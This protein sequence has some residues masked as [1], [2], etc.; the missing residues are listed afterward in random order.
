MT[1]IIGTK[2]KDYLVGDDNDDQIFGLDDDD[3][4]V[5]NG[6]ND[7]LN[8]GAGGDHMYGGDGNDSYFV[9][10]RDDLVVEMRG[11]GYDYVHAW[12]SYTLP[13]NVEGLMLDGP[14][15]INGIGNNIDNYMYG[16]ASSNVLWGLGGDDHI[17]GEGGADLMYGGLGDDTFYV[18][19]AYDTIFEYLDEGDDKVLA[20]VDYKLP[21]NVENLTL[22][23]KGTALNGTGNDLD[24]EIWGNIADNTLSGEDGGD[25]L[26][27]GIGAD[28][29]IGGDGDDTYYVDDVGDQV[30]ET[31]AK[32]GID[33]V[34]SSISYTL[35]A[36]EERLLL[37]DAGGAI[38]GIGNDLDNEIAGNGY[39]NVLTGGDGNDHFRLFNDP[40]ISEDDTITD[41]HAGDAYGDVIEMWGYN[42]AGGFAELLP[43][44][45]QV[46]NDVVGNFDSF[47]T[48]TLQ[49]VQ[50]SDLNANDFL[51][52]N[53]V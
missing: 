30:I 42:L 32:G 51:F 13:G 11:G 52:Y 49:N 25:V 26:I 36:F 21:D 1:M 46:G 38:D 40:S 3:V 23:D 31:S 47:N 37:S 7:W 39:S 24:N 22:L 29:M 33:Q 34:R 48:L 8:G 50:L 16:N 45:S 43:Y 10:S 35:G 53:P 18:D 6:G 17:D 4:L 2:G 41:F 19:D 28:T 15:E 44:L 27:G 14:G 5:G 20:S 9:D 12:I